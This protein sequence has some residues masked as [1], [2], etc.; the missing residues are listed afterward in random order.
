MF[1]SR[2]PRRIGRA[3]L[4]ARELLEVEAGRVGKLH[5]MKSSRVASRPSRVVGRQCRRRTTS[6]RSLVKCSSGQNTSDVPPSANEKM[7]LSRT[8]WWPALH[9]KD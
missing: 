5:A 4:R 2:T 1:T 7:T 8:R 3:S 9:W 6:A